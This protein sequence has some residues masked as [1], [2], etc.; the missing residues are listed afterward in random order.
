MILI[1]GTVKGKMKSCVPFSETTVNGMERGKETEG[2]PK[3]A[4]GPC[5]G[6]VAVGSWKSDPFGSLL[7]YV[8]VS[9]LYKEVYLVSLCSM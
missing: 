9:T 7:L 6:K 3:S 5:G 4:P 1:W 8:G 2:S